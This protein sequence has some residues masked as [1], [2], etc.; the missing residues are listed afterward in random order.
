[1]NNYVIN[2]KEHIFLTWR[3]LASNRARAIKLLQHNLR[4]NLLQ[5]GLDHIAV[6]DRAKTQRENKTKKIKQMIKDYKD[7]KLRQ[8]VNLWK[9]VYFQYVTGR[10]GD[11]T[12]ENFHS[13]AN[14]RYRRA[15]V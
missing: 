15:A 11:L 5:Y 1:M 14:A 2:R 8:A 4:K 10:T 9:Q 12:T 3:R 7:G 6:F 13:D